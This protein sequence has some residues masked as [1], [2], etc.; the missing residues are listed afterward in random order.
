[1]SCDVRMKRLNSERKKQFIVVSRRLTLFAYLLAGQVRVAGVA[2]DRIRI[3]S[4]GKLRDTLSAQHL[5]S[6]NRNHMQRGCRGGH[7]DRA[8][9]YLRHF[10]SV[11]LHPNVSFFLAVVGWPVISLPRGVQHIA[12]SVSVFCWSVHS[13]N[14]K[15]TPPDF[16]KFS[17]ARY[18][19]LGPP[20]TAS[21][22]VICVL[23][24]LWMMS[25]WPYGALWDVT[26]M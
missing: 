11:S 22:Y 7:I 1:M 18:L 19:W 14:S 2:A 5:I 10:G 15:T 3:A 4:S 8:W 13:R 17:C 23:P 26:A 9:W 25:H 16:V 21:W 12:M 24:V 6:C 20:L